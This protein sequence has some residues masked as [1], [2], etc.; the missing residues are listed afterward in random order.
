MRF[1]NTADTDLEE[2]DVKSITESVSETSAVGTA[3]ITR[4]LKKISD[5]CLFP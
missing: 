1:P 3:L 5:L 2:G 4:E